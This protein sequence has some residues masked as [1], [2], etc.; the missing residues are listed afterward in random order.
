MRSEPQGVRRPG[1]V[2]T[3]IKRIALSANVTGDACK[4]RICADR[5]RTGLAHIDAS[6]DCRRISADRQKSTVGR[7]CSNV[8]DVHQR[9]VGPRLIDPILDL[10]AIERVSVRSGY[11]IITH[12]KDGIGGTCQRGR[13][14]AVTIE[15]SLDITKRVDPS[16]LLVVVI[17]A[18]IRA[19]KCTVG[20]TASS[21]WPARL[22][23]AGCQQRT[24][25]QHKGRKNSSKRRES[26]GSHKYQLKN[27]TYWKKARQSALGSRRGWR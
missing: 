9:T 11:P 14:I 13:D 4:D 3:A 17:I 1:I 10:D 16:S 21:H 5:T 24:H 18:H 23:G 27:G 7:A 2:A 25:T 19:A 26:K 12:R 8:I 22:L 20:S 15:K 6:W